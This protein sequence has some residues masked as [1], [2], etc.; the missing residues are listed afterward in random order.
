MNCNVGWLEQ[1]VR[2][3]IGVPTAGAYFYVRHFSF[4]WSIVLLV[5]GV[6]LLVTAIF[7]RCPIHHI[8]GTSTAP[9]P[10]AL[11]QSPDPQG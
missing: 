1:V 5:I 4:I 11:V 7:R 3:M 2:L 8:L 6:S 10:P 9:R